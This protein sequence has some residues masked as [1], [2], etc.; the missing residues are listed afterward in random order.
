[1]QS[2]RRQLG[3]LNCHQISTTPAGQTPRL[4]VVLCHGYG[5]SGTDLVGLVP[6]LCQI[7]D[8]F[9]DGVEWL[10]PE[11]PLSLA[12]YGLPGGR[13]WWE[14]SIARLQMQLSQ[15]RWH[16]LRDTNPDGIDEARSALTES[17]ELWRT[18]CSLPMSR[19]VLGGFSQGAMVAIETTAALTEP[20]A[21]LIAFSGALIRESAWRSGLKSKP[22]LPVFQSHG[23]YDNVLPYQG[24][25]WLRDMLAEAGADVE[26][27]EFS[28]GH[29]ISFEVL[30]VAAAFLRK[31]LGATI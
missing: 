1:M 6:A 4:G 10:F 20:P 5:A 26:F 14:L 24:G 11:A 17:I 2:Q 28:G 23:Q 8:S 19:V 22:G 7:D 18:E 9:A 3:S 12:E 25:I 30:E 21:G 16:E 31:R 29:Q 27:V 15:G 13:A